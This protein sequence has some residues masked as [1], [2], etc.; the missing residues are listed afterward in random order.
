MKRKT[1]EGWVRVVFLAD[2]DEEMNCPFCK[3]DYAECPCPGPN[4]EGY[5]FR[6]KDGILE[7]KKIKQ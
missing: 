5:E 7:A 4:S 3:V 6:E 1:H 2:C